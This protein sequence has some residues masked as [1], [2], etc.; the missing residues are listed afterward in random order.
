[1]YNVGQIISIEG[2]GKFRIEDSHKGCTDCH[3]VNTDINTEP[4]ATCAKICREIGRSN[5]KL[6][7]VFDGDLDDYLKYHEECGSLDN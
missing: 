1:M 7:K 6:V 5:I 2:L 3:N 4:C